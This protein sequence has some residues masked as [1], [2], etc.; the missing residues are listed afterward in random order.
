MRVS[1]IIT[2]YNYGRFLG[3]AIQSSLAQ[4]VLPKDECEVLVVDDGS[5]DNSNEV[6]ESYLPDIRQIRHEKQRGL[7]AAVNTGIKNSRGAYVLRLD[8]DDWLDRHAAF[9]LS[10]FLDHNKE[11]GFVWPDYYIYDEYE[12]VI[13]RI[14]EPQGAGI[15]F[16]KQLLIDIGLYD[17]EMLVHEDKDIL[18]RCID[19]YPG[20]HLKMPL[21]RYYRHGSNLTDQEEMVQRYQKRLVSKHGDETLDESLTIDPGFAK[22][23]D[24][25]K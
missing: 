7:P 23:S 6:I 25:G 19:Q 14:S 8:A 5:T 9:V 21:Y 24:T 16:R 15:M 10:Y 22:P 2:N 17:E 3:R 12:R 4:T 18:F 13:D 1:I 11:I 20:Y